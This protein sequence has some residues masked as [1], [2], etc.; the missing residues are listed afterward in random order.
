[1][2]EVQR[3]PRSE[4]KCTPSR[5]PSSRAPSRR[6]GSAARTRSQCSR[7]DR[8][9]PLALSRDEGGAF[10]A[11]PGCIPHHRPARSLRAAPVA[12]HHRPAQ[13]GDQ[14]AALARRQRETPL[15]ELCDASNDRETEPAPKAARPCRVYALAPPKHAVE[16]NVLA[17]DGAAERPNERGVT[18]ITYV[19]TDEGWCYLAVIV[20]LFSRAVVGWSLDTTLATTLPLRALDAALQR[21]RPSAG[22]LHHSDRGRQYTSADYRDALLELGVTVSM[23]RKGNCWDNAVAE[24]FFATLKTEL[25]HDRRW[26]SRLELRDAVFEYIEVRDAVCPTQP[27]IGS[28]ALKGISGMHAL[29][30]AP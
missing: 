15:L 24:S 16:P 3:E 23:S 18:D 20:D 22:L 4:A 5:A 6:V 29:Y 25:I 30:C 1:M 9:A 11:C 26:R 12:L 8:F 28:F 14:P 7:R 17:R 27:P 10:A 19:W 21:R 13:L 2:N